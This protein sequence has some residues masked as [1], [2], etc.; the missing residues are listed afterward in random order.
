MVFPE[1]HE[2]RERRVTEASAL[3]QGTVER[4]AR[5][6]CPPQ[7]IGEAARKDLLNLK[8]YL[9]EALTALEDIERLRSL[10]DEQIAQRSAF[11]IVCW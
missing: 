9:E 3:L 2:D 1:G 7:L 5:G 11:R 4:L 10:T 8:P 6:D